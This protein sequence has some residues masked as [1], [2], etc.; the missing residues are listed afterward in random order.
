MPQAALL[1]DYSLSG[2]LPTNEVAGIF[3]GFTAVGLL[4]YRFHRNPLYDYPFNHLP[5]T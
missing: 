3:I 4:P 1:L 5:C 2:H